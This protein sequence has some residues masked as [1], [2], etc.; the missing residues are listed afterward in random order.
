MID[1]PSRSEA[2]QSQDPVAEP[3]RRRPPEGPASRHT[4]D[5]DALVARTTTQLVRF[6]R[7]KRFR[8][9]CLRGLGLS[10]LIAAA[11]ATVCLVLWLAFGRQLIP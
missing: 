3:S 1:P 2:E 4:E 6:G 9:S 8:T 7:R 10:L 5:L 11:V